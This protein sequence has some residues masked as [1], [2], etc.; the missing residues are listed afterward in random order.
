MT[1]WDL[2]RPG[3]LLTDRGTRQRPAAEGREVRVQRDERGQIAV[4]IIGLSVVAMML[5]VVAVAV[6]SLHLSRMRL[7]DVADGAAL[8]AADALDEGAYN[9]GVGTAVPLSSA[10]VTSEAT[11]Y[12]DRR[13]LPPNVRAWGLMPGTGTPDGETAVVVMR[14]VADVPLVGPL[15]DA[16]NTPVTITVT[17]RARADLRP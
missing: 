8:A 5:I 1:P 15:L 6:T 9:R 11:A 10:S 7:I 14:G 17:S 3:W 4:L 2:R 16:I 12:V 13:P